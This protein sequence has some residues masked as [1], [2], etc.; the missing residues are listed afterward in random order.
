MC[1]DK[2][3]MKKSFLVT[4]MTYQNTSTESECRLEEKRKISS[5]FCWE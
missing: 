4:D 5:D 1:V 2:E 3:F